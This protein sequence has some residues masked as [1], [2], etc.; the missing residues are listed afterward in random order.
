MVSE[1]FFFLFYFLIFGSQM[2]TKQTENIITSLED[3]VPAWT[4]LFV[5]K[6]RFTSYLKMLCNN[7]QDSSI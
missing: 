6:P 1:G 7:K 5:I 2:G 4:G 3:I